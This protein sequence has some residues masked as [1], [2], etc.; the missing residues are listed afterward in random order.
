M[1]S[2][3]S[4]LFHSKTFSKIRV[5]LRSMEIY[6]LQPALL[7]KATTEQFQGYLPYYINAK[8]EL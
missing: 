3:I 7:N 6:M 1:F 5:C 4:H 2:H 8:K